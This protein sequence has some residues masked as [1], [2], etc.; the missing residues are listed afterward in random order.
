MTIGTPSSWF[1]GKWEMRW[2]LEHFPPHAEIHT[3]TEAFGGMAGL[4]LRKEPSPV[5]VYNDINSGLV[6]F[7]R[8]VREYPEAL[9]RAVELTPVAYEEWYRSTKTW[10]SLAEAPH[11]AEECVEA[12]RRFI[13]MT[14]QSMASA[15]A[16]SF[17]AV[18]KHTRRGMA[19]NCSAWANMPE[20]IRDCGVRMARVQIEHR[21]A[22]HVLNKYDTDR[23]LHYVDPPYVPS[24][25]QTGIYSAVGGEEMTIDQHRELLTCLLGLRGGVVLS[26]YDHPLYNELLLDWQRVR[27]VVPCRSAVHPSGKV[28]KRDT[29]I[30]VLWIKKWGDA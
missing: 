24:T 29:R 20:I 13:V 17:Q 12:A 18:I 4:L 8:A 3:Y 19:S 15:P 25:C 22:V 5:E 27:R 10:R 23:T 6:A 2:I 21:S 28:A 14:R 11:T 26:G 7:W 1:G 9:A 16:R 30:E